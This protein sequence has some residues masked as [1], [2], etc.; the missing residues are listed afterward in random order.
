M[1]IAVFGPVRRVGALVGAE[2]VDL[3]AASDA[4]GAAAISP[5]LE[6]FLCGGSAMLASARDAV[7]F[8][9]GP[10]RALGGE[11][12]SYSVGSVELHAPLLATTRLFNALSNYA[13][14]VGAIRRMRGADIADADVADELRSAGPR[15][16]MKHARNVRGPGDVVRY[17]A[18]AEWLDYE[19]EVVAVI[20]RQVRDVSVNEASSAIG[21]VTLQNDWS[22]R[23]FA[24][25]PEL[26]HLKNFDTSAA[27][28]PCIVTTEGLD[29]QGIEFAT[30]VNGELR[31]H[32]TTRDMIFSFAEYVAHLSRDQ[33]LYPGDM[34]SGGTPA[35]T[36]RDASVID[37]TGTVVESLFVT[38]GDVVEVSSPQIGSL[39]TTVVGLGDFGATNG[40]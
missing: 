17:P 27:L 35:G 14:H 30:R 5:E 7:E 3:A 6:D 39:V 15:H 1:R 33:T 13:D 16:F 21:G 20:S 18:R 12:L 22:I 4:L 40:I 25:G 28:G 29:L 34:I 36:A 24:P 19:A 11:P 32:G 9:T 2:V 31:Q 38:P 23:Q 10:G 8:A 37:H 26:Q